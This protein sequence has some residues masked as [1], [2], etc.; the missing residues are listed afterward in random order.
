MKRRFTAE[1][2]ICQLGEECTRE[3]CNESKKLRRG[4]APVS[5]WRPNREFYDKMRITFST[6]TVPCRHRDFLAM[7]SSEHRVAVGLSQEVRDI[8]RYLGCRVLDT[9]DAYS[10]WYQPKHTCE[11]VFRLHED[12]GLED[13]NVTW[14]FIA[15]Q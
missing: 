11:K 8:L 9:F 3:P 7:G 10:P 2:H 14:L 12:Y 15:G 4:V 13:L 5:Q 1:L 6:G